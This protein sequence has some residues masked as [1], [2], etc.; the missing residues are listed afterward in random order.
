MKFTL[1]KCLF[2]GL[3]LTLCFNFV[4][5]AYLKLNRSEG[6]IVKEY[7]EKV[8]KEFFRDKKVETNRFK[9]IDQLTNLC[10]YNCKVPKEFTTRFF[11]RNILSHID[12]NSFLAKDN[13][14]DC[15][16]N[17]DKINNGVTSKQGEEFYI[18]DFPCKTLCIKYEKHASS[19]FSSFKRAEKKFEANQIC[20]DFCSAKPNTKPETCRFGSTQKIENC[21]PCEKS[22]DNSENIP[23]IYTD[24]IPGFNPDTF[25][26]NCYEKSNSQY[27]EP[28]KKHEEPKKEEDKKIKPKPVPETCSNVCKPSSEKLQCILSKHSK[29]FNPETQKPLDCN[30]CV[31][32]Q[33]DKESKIDCAK[34]FSVLDEKNNNNNCVDGYEIAPKPIVKRLS[35]QEPLVETCENSCYYDQS[36]HSKQL[37]LCNNKVEDPKL[38]NKCEKKNKSSK[39]DCEKCYKRI[40]KTEC[41][42]ETS[43]MLSEGKFP[44]ACHLC[45]KGDENNKCSQKITQTEVS[46]CK[47]EKKDT[48]IILLGMIKTDLVK[49]YDK[50]T[51][52]DTKTKLEGIMMNTSNDFCKNICYFNN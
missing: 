19:C 47:I 39:F 27:C 17:I 42:E 22:S 38:C 49:E 9:Q 34:C 35:V 3:F 37:F 24:I 45:Y 30:T 33:A 10:K 12:P 28:A 1:N 4:L 14:F 31:K 6:S 29:D 18:K 23:K 20:K 25:C 52:T 15:T 48:A 7:Y 40:D 50:E 5:N 2:Y 46:D 13:C 41:T 16:E 21:S 32:K 36:N 43:K 51:S 26:S 44:V 11:C 8:L